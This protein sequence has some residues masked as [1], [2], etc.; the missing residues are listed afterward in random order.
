M[1]RL[2]EL[3]PEEMTPEQRRVY[4]A[5]VAGPRGRVEAPHRAWLYAPELA[6]LAQQ[7][8]AYCRFG[9]RLPARLREIA[10]LVT[11]AHYR[12]EYEWYAHVRIAHEAGVPPGVT[13]AIRRGETPR[14]DDPAERIGHRVALEL[15]R[16]HRLSQA[17]FDEAVALLGL[18]ALVDLV[19]A[20]GYYGL[21]SLTLNAFEVPT[22]DGSAAFG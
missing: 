13:E 10:I 8:G 5:I 22:P 7:L 17:T 11:G 14:L 19:G 21:V 16:D 12:A 6:D 15:N 4:D 1:S 9:S 20:V 3:R 2:P 18:P